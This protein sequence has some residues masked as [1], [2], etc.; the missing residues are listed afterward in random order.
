MHAETRTNRRVFDIPGTITGPDD[1][2]IAVRFDLI[3]FED[4]V[5]GIPGPRHSYGIL[6]FL[7][8]LEASIESRLL[9]AACL[10]LT[11]VGIQA[12]LCLYKLNSFTLKETIT[13]F[14]TVTARVAA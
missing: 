2:T 13:E 3:E 6:R 1:L 12:P 8:P 7:E 14:S 4:L 11:G 9:S 10:I 5:D